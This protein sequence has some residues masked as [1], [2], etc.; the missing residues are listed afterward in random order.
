VKGRFRTP[1][2]IF[3]WER[4]TF[5]PCENWDVTFFEEFEPATQWKIRQALPRAAEHAPSL[6]PAFDGEYG[7]SARTT[8]EKVS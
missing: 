6:A 8:T 5:A 1:L 2:N 3:G 7:E 4:F